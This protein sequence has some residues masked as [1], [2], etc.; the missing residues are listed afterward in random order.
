[1]VVPNVVGAGLGPASQT[2]ACAGLSPYPEPVTSEGTAPMTRTVATAL[3]VVSTLPA[4]G[5]SLG[6]ATRVY[7]RYP[8]QTGRTLIG[9]VARCLT[10]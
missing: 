3:P 2:I 1:M 8:R 6:R 5:T 4:A 7:L 9:V 10:G